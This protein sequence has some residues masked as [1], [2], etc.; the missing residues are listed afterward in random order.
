[1]SWGLFKY[2]IIFKVKEYLSKCEI[3]FIHKLNN[4][5]N[6]ADKQIIISKH[7]LE[8]LLADITYFNNKLELLEFQ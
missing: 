4:F 3:C 6:P 2:E 8:R 5:I 7:P 1:M